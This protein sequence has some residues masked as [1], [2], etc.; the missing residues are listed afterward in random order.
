MLGSGH[1][2]PRRLPTGA[3]AR[4]DR[5]ALTRAQ[6]QLVRYVSPGVHTRVEL[7]VQLETGVL[8][9]GQTLDVVVHWHVGVPVVV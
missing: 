1:E 8:P 5:A 6:R 7:N 4:A 2:G 3:R 9:A